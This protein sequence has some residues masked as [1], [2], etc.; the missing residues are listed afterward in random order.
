MTF[1]K[2]LQKWDETLCRMAKDH[3]LDWF[4]LA[5]ETCD[6]YEM[7]G[8][9]A[10]HGMP[11]HYGHWS[12]GKSF[13]RNHLMYNAGMQGLPYELIINSNP[14]LAYLMEENPMYLQVLIM[15]HCIGHSDFFKNNITFKHTHPENIILRMRNAKRYIDQLIEDPS[16]GV[17]QVENT[18]DSAHTLAYNVPRRY[19]PY[20]KQADQ[21]KKLV[22][23]IKTGMYNDK[24]FVPDPEMVPLKAEVNVLAFLADQ[25]PGLE[26]WQ[27]EILKIVEEEAHYFMPQ[28]RTKIMNEGWAA[29]WHYRLMHELELPSGMHI[30]FLKTHNEV[31]RP[32][33]GSINPYHLGFHLFRK[34]EERFGLEECFI[35]RESLNDESFIRQYLTQ[36]DCE[37]LELFSYSLHKDEYKV[38]DVGD[39]QGWKNIREDLIKQV[40][41]NSIPIIMIDGI[42]DSN[43]LC[44]IHEHDGRDLELNYAD[45]VVQHISNLW[46]DVVKLDTIIEDEP[47]EI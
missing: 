17:D 37:E 10:Y 33:A 16:I 25:S 15:A 23:D 13:E 36:E 8:S 31:I 7:I 39:E 19:E 6:Y 30:P 35:A 5:Y 4:P 11:S 40:G 47:F 3:G 12:Y 24:N 45:A 38:D 18:L 26:E 32:H 44:L 28:I 43:V 21:K 2:E 1:L 22:E 46:G 42:D 20:I 34:I 41:G 27:R 29:Y 14:S 9:M